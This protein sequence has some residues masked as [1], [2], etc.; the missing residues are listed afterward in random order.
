MQQQNLIQA[1][2]LSRR[3]GPTLAVDGLDLTLRKG[4][5][6]GLLGPNGAGK[7][8]TMK[9]LTGCLAP[10]SGVIRICGHD[11]QEQPEA[12]KRHLG[13]MPEMP[14]LY[15]ELSVEE[16]LGF[17]A[18]LHRVE[19][20]Q[21]GAA[22]ERA[23]SSCG[24]HAMRR[25][26]VG[27]LSKGYQQRVGLAQAI[28]HNPDVIVLDEPTIGLDPIQIR[29]IRSLIAEL[30]RAHSVLISS[31]ILPEVQAVCDRVM[32][33]S[34]GK[35]VYADS[36][37]EAA[38][39]RYDS[40]LIGL[41]RPPDIDALAALTDVERVEAIDA[42]RFRLHCATDSTAGAQWAAEAVHNDW[43]LFELTPERRTL[44]DVFVELTASDSAAAAPASEL[45]QT[46]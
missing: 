17:A 16:M 8:T 14:P 30:G 36:V 9:M 21:R 11:I 32:I 37:A 41:Q 34:G 4:E 35:V 24:L 28:I 23:I 22:I 13:Y 1:E 26:L 44:E 39:A 12:A 7:S 19:R 45:E 42:Q 43:G 46:A 25:R 15:P 27:N 18:R 20:P 38:K 10:S 29:E 40:V 2:G 33:V 6:L 31:H 3:Y 5:I